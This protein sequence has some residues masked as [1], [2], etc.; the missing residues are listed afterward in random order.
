MTIG[1]TSIDTRVGGAPPQSRDYDSAVNLER[2]VKV[3]N[4]R[5]DPM[6]ERAVERLDALLAS[7]QQLRTD[8]PRGYYIDIV[9]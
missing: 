2:R 4:F 3:S 9:V 1:P 7:G 6:I 8:V 5:R